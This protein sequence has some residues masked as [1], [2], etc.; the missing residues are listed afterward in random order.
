MTIKSFY[1]L[2]NKFNE[3]LISLYE[4]DN[5][6][7]IIS[8]YMKLIKE[9]KI[10]REQYNLFNQLE[11]G[12]DKFIVENK[13]F[14]NE[15]LNEILKPFEKYSRK[16]IYEEN[17]KV[18]N[19][20]KEN[21]LID[22]NNIVYTSFDNKLISLVENIIHKNSKDIGELTVIR[23]SAINELKVKQDK[24]S[25]NEVKT[26]EEKIAEF[27]EKYQGTLTNEEMDI[28]KSLM[29][30]GEND[31]PKILREYQKNVLDKLNNLIKE[32]TDIE[33][34]EKFLQLKEQVLFDDETVQLFEIR[35]LIDEIEIKEDDEKV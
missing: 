21:N 34:K 10:L 12:V 20:L 31:K 7:N 23:L 30:Y 19:F 3:H 15:Y 27:N 24:D 25:V 35:K 4:D 29:T 8:K 22:P 13:I 5:R 6:K 33:L 16:E 26:V 2:N 32:S 18:F 17:E 14:A 11:E 28:V 9:N 1:V